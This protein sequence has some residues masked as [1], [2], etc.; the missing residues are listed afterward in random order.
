MSDSDQYYVPHPSKWPII[1]AI[2]LGMLAIGA[3]TCFHGDAYG[4]YILGIGALC[5]VYIMIGW[6]SAVINES[7]SDLYNA[8][9]DRTFRWGMFWFIFSE[10]MFFAGF[11]GALFYMR[12]FSVPWLGGEGAFNKLGT[13]EFLWPSFVAQWPLLHNPSPQLFPDPTHDM[14]ALWLPLINT[15]TLLTSSV[16][17]TFA[18]HALLQNKRIILST[19]LFATILLGLGFL[20][21]QAIE[22]H[23]AYTVFKM[24]LDSGAYG[25]TFFTLTGFHG[26]HVSIG[27]IMLSVMLIRCLRGHFT[28]QHHFAFQAAAWYWHFVDVVWLCL[29]MYV[30]VLPLR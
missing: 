10:V 29:F 7:Q 14:P 18:H 21:L 11:F 1:T 20:C 17:I 15:F 25:T 30:Y 28:P 13:H 3:A 26:L 12:N 9:V 4:P 2:G 27:A 6:F 19:M 16:T 24:R 8:Q 5:M 22:Y 23:E